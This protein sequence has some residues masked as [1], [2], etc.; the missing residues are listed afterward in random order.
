MRR[1][2]IG[3]VLLAVSFAAG[4]QE[5]PG[6]ETIRVWVQIGIDAEGR[7]TRVTYPY[8]QCYTPAFMDR[9]RVQL[10]MRAFDPLLIDGRAVEVDTPARVDVALRPD[11]DGLVATI[12]AVKP[13]PRPVTMVAPGYP[14][15]A[16]AAVREGRIVFRCALGEDGRCADIDLA[17]SGVNMT[18]ARAARDALRRWTFEL[19]RYDGRPIT[20]TVAVPFRFTTRPAGEEPADGEADAISAED[21]RLPGARP[22]PSRTFPV[23]SQT[24][25][26]T[27]QL[28]VCR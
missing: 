25:R 3:G 18:L 7:T 28:Q 17:D 5:M 8:A 2:W 27:A 20:G 16:L 19:P 26:T 22:A 14:A 15:R 10:A 12:V 6:V 1:S 13:M 24:A 23:G 21:W 9:L 11:A 4:A